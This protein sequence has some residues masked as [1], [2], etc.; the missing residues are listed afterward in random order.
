MSIR[1]DS[2]YAIR[3]EEDILWYETVYGS[4]KKAPTNRQLYAINQIEKRSKTNP[5][6]VGVTMTEASE[7][8]TRYGLQKYNKKRRHYGGFN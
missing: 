4:K 1:T 8:I 7:Y 5:K 6:F 2:Y 3:M